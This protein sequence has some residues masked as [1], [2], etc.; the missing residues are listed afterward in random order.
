MSLL[1]QMNDMPT[2]YYA[3]LFICFFMRQSEKTVVLTYAIIV[4]NTE[5]LLCND[6]YLLFFCYRYTPEELH[7]MVD[8]KPEKKDDD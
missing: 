7:A 4:T 2:V 6:V 8:L 1:M 5:Y 3:M